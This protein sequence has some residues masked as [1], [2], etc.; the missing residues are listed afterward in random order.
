MKGEPLKEASQIL[1]EAGESEFT[2]LLI[3]AA[4]YR[5]IADRAKEEGRTAAQVFQKALLQYLQPAEPIKASDQVPGSDQR[6]APALVFKRK[7]P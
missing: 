7:R 5:M 1:G 6:P 2:F 3:P 4:T